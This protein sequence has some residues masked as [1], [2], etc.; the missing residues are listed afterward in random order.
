MAE[1][2]FAD[3]RGIYSKRAFFFLRQN[4]RRDREPTAEL[5]RNAKPKNRRKQRFS[6]NACFR[7]KHFLDKYIS[8]FLTTRIFNEF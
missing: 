7:V 2:A 5:L 6:K 8:R 3:P 1:Q 4:R